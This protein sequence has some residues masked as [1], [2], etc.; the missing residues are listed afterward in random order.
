MYILKTNIMVVSI[1]PDPTIEEF[2]KLLEDSINNLS[3]ES[4][5]KEEEYLKLLGTKFEDK[6][7]DIMNENAKGTPFENSIKL[8]SGQKFPDIIA[9]KFFGVEVKTTKQNHWRTTGNSVLEGTRV[10]G[11]ER[12]FMLFGKMHAPVE[13]KYRHY[14]DCL[15]EVVVTHSPRYLIDMNLEKGNTIF[16]KINIPYDSLRIEENP[17][18]PILNYYR[19]LLKNGE[20]VWWLNQEEERSKSLI[21]KFWNSLPI[22]VRNKYVAK[23][24]VFFPEV[25]KK[26]FN[27]FALWLYE[28]ESIICPNV[29]DPFSAGGQGDIEWKNKIYSNIPRIIVKLSDFIECIKSEISFLTENELLRY[30]GTEKFKDTKTYWIDMVCQNTEGMGLSINLKEFLRENI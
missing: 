10:D 24:M 3:A 18:K 27:R 1:N 19:S 5:T 12:I 16:D 26:D 22:A 13:F 4:K 25:F 17:I 30:W 28:N 14:E 7:L 9:N 23:G 20:E 2:N 21:I 29:R 8:I 6:V 15:S 11:I